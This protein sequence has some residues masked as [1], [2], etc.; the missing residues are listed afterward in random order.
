MCPIVQSFVRGEKQTEAL[1]KRLRNDAKCPYA[2]AILMP[3]QVVV[4]VVS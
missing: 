4:V 3:M 2:Y 1:C